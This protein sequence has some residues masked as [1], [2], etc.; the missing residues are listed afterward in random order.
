MTDL[1]CVFWNIFD[2]DYRRHI[3]WE[4]HL[5]IETVECEYVILY[6]YFT[7]QIR[8]VVKEHETIDLAEHVFHTVVFIFQYSYFRNEAS[9]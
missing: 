3:R 4:L 7:V 5:L 6:A 8:E 2:G 9:L 1:T